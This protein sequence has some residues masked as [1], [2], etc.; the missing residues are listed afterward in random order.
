MLKITDD[1]TVCAAIMYTKLAIAK[2]RAVLEI[3]D[4]LICIP[5]TVRIAESVAHAEDDQRACSRTGS[6]GPG[7]GARGRSTRGYAA[8]SNAGGSC[9]S[10]GRRHL[11]EEKEKEELAACTACVQILHRLRFSHVLM[12]A[13]DLLC[14]RRSESWGLLLG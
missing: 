2:A 10:H 9:D 8:P 13:C 12:H 7:A 1:V 3:Q 4:T 11:E 6:C 14:W 5:W